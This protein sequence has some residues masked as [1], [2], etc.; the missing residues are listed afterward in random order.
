MCPALATKN[1]PWSMKIKFLELLWPVHGVNCV[2]HVLGLLSA[3]LPLQQLEARRHLRAG[4]PDNE[5]VQ[6]EVQFAM[7][8][9]AAQLAAVTSQLTQRAAEAEQQIASLDELSAALLR[10]IADKQTAMSLEEK[11]ALLDGRRVPAV[12]PTPSILSV[13]LTRNLESR[14]RVSLSLLIST[15][16]QSVCLLEP[17]MV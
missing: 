1:W 3:R 17:L 2:V 9:E 8:A 16:C 13:S 12:P 11:V 5:A 14:D 7:A 4:R 10:N 15:V 6:D